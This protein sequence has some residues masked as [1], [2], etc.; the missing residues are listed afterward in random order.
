[1]GTLKSRLTRG[2]ERAFRFASDSPA[3]AAAIFYVLQTQIRVLFIASVEHEA[4][5]AC[6]EFSTHQSTFRKHTKVRV[7]LLMSMSGHMC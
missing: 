4:T 6:E 7:C 5:V 1:M 2:V 3:L